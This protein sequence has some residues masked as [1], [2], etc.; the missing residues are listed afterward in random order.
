MINPIDDYTP[1][2]NSLITINDNF[3][4]LN[5]RACLNQENYNNN[6]VPFFNWVQS[7][8]AQFNQITTVTMDLS[9]QWN[10][11]S[12][13]VHN[14]SGYWL[15]PITILYASTFN[16]LVNHTVIESWLNATFGDFTFHDTQ[17]LQ[18]VSIVKNYDPNSLNGVAITPT[19]V[20]YLYSLANQYGHSFDEVSTYLSFANIVNVQISSINYLLKLNNRTDLDITS[21]SAANKLFDSFTI[22]DGV[23]VSSL[24]GSIPYEQLVAIYIYLEQYNLAYTIYNSHTGVASMPD[25][26]IAALNIQNIR[27]MF[28]YKTCYRFNPELG[29]KYSPDCNIDFCVKQDCADCYGSLNPNDLYPAPKQCQGQKYE[30]T[31]CGGD[32]Y[33]SLNSIFGGYIGEYINM[34]IDGVAEK[35][36]IQRTSNSI[37]YP[38]NSLL[39]SY[40]YSIEN[41]ADFQGCGTS[42]TSTSTSTTLSGTTSTT[43]VTTG[44]TTVPPTTTTPIP[45]T[46]P[47]TTHTPTSTTPYPTSTTQHPTTPPP[48]STTT[49]TTLP[50]TTTTT[51]PPF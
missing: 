21:N 49:S 38:N 29:W 40:R 48:P 11:T 33:V 39:L 8:S 42:T 17:I 32:V 27:G 16:A 37:V 50:P 43:T 14:V 36:F 45:T 44:P 1:L 30:L 23:L 34:I 5:V 51:S 12:T 6:L 7:L 26:V 22:K 15:E 31:T 41:V 18:V 10:D 24:L 25:N 4:Y 9:A 13:I 20:E 2:G 46:H 3:S 28:F 19:T 47:P 35:V